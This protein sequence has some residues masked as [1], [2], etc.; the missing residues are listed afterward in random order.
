MASSS[1]ELI[2]KLNDMRARLQTTHLENYYVR[3]LECAR[4]IQ[5]LSG[6][7]IRK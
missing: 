1:L 4:S 5:Q 2:V 3:C 6:A 7:E